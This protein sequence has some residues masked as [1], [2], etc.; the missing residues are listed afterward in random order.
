MKIELQSRLEAVKLLSKMEELISKRNTLKDEEVNRLT[1][2]QEREK[3]ITEVRINNQS[4]AS[5]TKQTKIVSDQLQEKRDYLQQIEQ[6]LDEGSSERHI[7]YK[8]L[9]KRDEMMESFMETFHTNMILEKQ[10]DFIKD[11]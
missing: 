1:P 6:D 5:I 4:L 9:K 11:L 8:E 7:K 10:S 3:L 2:A